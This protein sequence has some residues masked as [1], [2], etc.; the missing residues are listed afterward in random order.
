[1][2]YNLLII[3]IIIGLLFL[4]IK[5]TSN[6]FIQLEL[7]DIN[8]YKK[9]ML[10]NDQKK[11]FNIQLEEDITLY[12]ED[13]RSKCN[14]IDCFRFDQLQNSLKK[15]LECNSQNGRCF[16]NS[17][18]GGNCDYCTSEDEKMNCYDIN[19]FGCANPENLQ[20]ND[21][22]EPYYI[23]V[24]DNNINSPF[25]KKCVFCWNILDNI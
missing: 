16:N 6:V 1:M 17:I 8:T 20:S 11:L 5:I 24:P 13:C 22:I 21:G 9:I 7:F 15:C 12:K 23:E 10:N 18:I 4:Y 25:D 19:N 2:I 14:Y 3:F